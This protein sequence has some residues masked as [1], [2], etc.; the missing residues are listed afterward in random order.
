MRTSSRY[1]TR[2]PRTK[3]AGLVDL[4]DAPEP[5]DSIEGL[6]AGTDIPSVLTDPMGGLG[7]EG[8]GG[9]GGRNPSRADAGA[10]GASGRDAERRESA[11]I[12]TTQS[13]KGRLLCRV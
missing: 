13:P 1:E 6:A 9:G 7:S 10:Q 8:E 4:N 11:T 12:S 2:L 3:A 5:G